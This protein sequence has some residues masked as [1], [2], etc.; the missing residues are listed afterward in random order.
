MV[1]NN[2]YNPWNCI[3]LAWFCLRGDLDLV[4]HLKTGVEITGYSLNLHL[5]INL[6]D[7]SSYFHAW[8]DLRENLSRLERTWEKTWGDLDIFKFLEFGDNLLSVLFFL[9]SFL[10]LP[11]WPGVLELIL[12]YLRGFSACIWRSSPG[13][14]Q[15]QSDWLL[16]LTSVFIDLADSTGHVITWEKTW[17]KNLRGW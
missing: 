17:G 5:R 2:Y 11:F 8:G 13:Q 10:I 9:A 6:R 3:K 14:R 4:F 7:F 1:W 15:D 16:K 12:L